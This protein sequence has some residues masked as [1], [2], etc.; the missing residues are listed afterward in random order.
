MSRVFKAGAPQPH[1]FNT[2]FFP[3]PRAKPFWPLKKISADRR[4]GERHQAYPFFE[5]A[6]AGQEVEG[7]FYEGL[8]VQRSSREHL[9]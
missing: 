4:P 3:Y 1:V 5:V 9:A 2:K 7:F 8:R 6:A